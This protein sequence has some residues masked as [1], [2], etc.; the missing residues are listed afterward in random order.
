MS[1]QRDF[2]KLAHKALANM[3]KISGF[4]TDVKQLAKEAEKQAKKGYL[5]FF[6]WFKELAPEDKE[7]IAGEIQHYTR[8]TKG[9][10]EKMLK[11]KFEELDPV[12]ENKKKFKEITEAYKILLKKFIKK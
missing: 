3:A 7:V 9:T 11:F 8:Q 4:P 12:D 10:I 2:V 5:Y 6:K 1:A